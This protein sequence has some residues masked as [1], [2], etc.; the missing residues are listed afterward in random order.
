[1]TPE[2]IYGKLISDLIMFYAAYYIGFDSG[3][4]GKKYSLIFWVCVGILFVGNIFVSPHV[5]PH[6]IK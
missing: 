4:H 3:K 6:L 1:M 2:Q 5:T